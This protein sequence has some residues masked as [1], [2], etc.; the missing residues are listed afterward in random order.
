MTGQISI[1]Y[2]AGA[3]IFFGSLVFLISNVMTALP[4]FTQAQQTDELTLATW[5]IS[6]VVMED[7]GRWSSTSDGGTDWQNHLG[8]IDIIGLQGED[9]LSREK[10]S[11]LTSL[12]QS[13]LREALR[14]GKKVNIA[15]ETVID[16]DT[17]NTF[18]QGASPDFI[19]EPAYPGFVDGEVHYGAKVLDDS[20][21]Y[22]LLT[23]NKHLGWYNRLRVSD[24]ADFTGSE[25]HNLTQTVFLP[26]SENTYTADAG[27]TEISGGNLLILRRSLGRAGN[28]PQGSATDI[29]SVDRYGVMDGNVVEVTFRVWN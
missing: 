16:V 19:T 12:N 11:A 9:G 24:D 15:A 26:V 18:Q 25:V 13:W 7:K 20:N 22:F 28:V 3:L 14:T 27:N 10:V 5:S 2:L 17:S 1:D 8:K 21:R 6:E 23:K 29:V 4:A